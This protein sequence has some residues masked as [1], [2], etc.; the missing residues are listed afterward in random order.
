MVFFRELDPQVLVAD[1]EMRGPDMAAAAARGVT[2]AINNRPDDEE[3]GQ[4]TSADLE[5]AARAA[6]LDYVHIPVRAE[7][8]QDKVA[9]LTEAL[10]G[11]EGRVLIF[12]KTGTRSCYLWA[13]AQ[14][15]AGASPELL[16][17]NARRAGYNLS[18]LMPWLKPGEDE[19]ASS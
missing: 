2:L 6:G 1:A 4:W 17:H 10:M 5:T 7:F 8:S 12:C 13:L 11:T 15:K 3:A 16:D 14:A 19:S 18:P 9:A